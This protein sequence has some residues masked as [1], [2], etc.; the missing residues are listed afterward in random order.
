M[1]Q[2]IIQA[3][4]DGDSNVPIDPELLRSMGGFQGLVEILK[5]PD[6]AEWFFKLYEWLQYEMNDFYGSH[7]EQMG[8][9][10][11]KTAPAALQELVMEGGRVPLVPWERHFNRYA[12]QANWKL[13]SLLGYLPPGFELR[14]SGKTGPVYSRIEEIRGD[15][16]VTATI[17]IDSKAVKTSRAQDMLLWYDKG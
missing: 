16:D 11:S 6:L 13:F 4:V 5:S 8:Q 12:K 14:L 10:V 3:I 1:T 17:D 15:F 2:E 7:K 9:A